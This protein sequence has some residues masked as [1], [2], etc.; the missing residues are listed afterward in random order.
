M[1]LSARIGANHWPS[2][3]ARLDHNRI[4]ASSELR[5]LS[6]LGIAILELN[7]KESKRIDQY[8][9]QFRYRARGKD[10][11]GAQVGRRAWDV[12]LT[13]AV[14]NHSN[15]SEPPERKIGARKIAPLIFL[16]GVFLSGVFLARRFSCRWPNR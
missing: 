1:S 12:F 4:S 9:N 2:P 8:G 7:Y 3:L 5:T 13:I 14:G 10:V 15:S 6:D 16:T 11:R